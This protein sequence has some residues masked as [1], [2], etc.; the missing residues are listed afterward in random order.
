MFFKTVSFINLQPISIIA[1]LRAVWCT[2]YVFQNKV[3]LDMLSSLLAVMFPLC[4]FLLVTKILSFSQ[5]RFG[6]D[7]PYVYA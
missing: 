6:L 4:C 7:N 3:T 5:L 2:N 1:E